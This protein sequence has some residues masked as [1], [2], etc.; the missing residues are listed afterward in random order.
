MVF[1]KKRRKL[2]HH[3]VSPSNTNLLLCDVKFKSGNKVIDKWDNIDLDN[4]VSDIK[5]KFF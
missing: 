4:L 2:R 5:K 3:K 1:G